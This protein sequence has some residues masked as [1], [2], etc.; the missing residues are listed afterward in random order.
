M[1]CDDASGI[2]LVCYHFEAG[3]LNHCSKFCLL[4]EFANTLNKVLIRV[5]IIGQKLSHERYSME[6]IIIIDLL[7]AWH[8]NFGE[9]QAHESATPPENSICFTQCFLPICNISNSESNG[10]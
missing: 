8:Y 9:F 5:F 10:V 3:F 7:K 1:H 6:A 4:W 2:I